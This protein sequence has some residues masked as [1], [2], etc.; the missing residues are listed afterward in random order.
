[1]ENIWQNTKHI[2]YGGLL[3]LGFLAV[4]ILAQ[5]PARPR[6]PKHQFIDTTVTYKLTKADA[7]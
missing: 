3:L 4:I 5:D 6:A 1:M 7:G 2:F